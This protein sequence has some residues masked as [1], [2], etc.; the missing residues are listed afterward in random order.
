MRQY[1]VYILG[2][3]SGTL[4]VGVTRDLKR[5]VWQH[6]AKCVPGFTTRYRIDRLLYYECTSD[7]RSAIAREKQVKRWR[8]EKKIRLIEAMNRD[9]H[10]LSE[11]WF[12]PVPDDG[13]GGV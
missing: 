3:A 7:V 8:R 10:D 6:K 5:R 11:G 12:E 9:W 1:Y 2:N 4:Y 13:V